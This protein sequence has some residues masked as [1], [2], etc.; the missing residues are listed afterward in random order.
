MGLSWQQGPPRHRGR[1]VPHGRA[2]ARAAAVRRA[3]PPADAGAFR[4]RVDRRQ[5]GRRPAARARPLPGRVLPARG[6][7]GRR[8]RRR[9][10]AR[11]A[12][13]PR[14][15][16]V[17]HGDAGDRSAARAAWQLHRPARHAD[18]LRDR[19]A[20]AWRAMDAFYEE[21]E[22]IVGHAADPYHR[23]DI[24]RT[25]RHLVV[26]AA[27]GSSPTHAPVVLYESGFAPRWYVPREDIDADRADARPTGRR[28]AR[29]RAWPATT[30]SA[31]RR[32]RPGPTARPGPRS[33]ASPTWSRSSRT[34]SRSSS[35]AGGSPS[36][37]GQTVIAARRRPRPG[38]RRDRLL[39]RWRRR[40]KENGHDC[41]P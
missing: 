6:R 28:S 3:A 1:A 24:R 12:P 9:P 37:P 35:T 5:R 36:N 18:V 31:D 17:V 39:E 27:T 14:R 30:T 33:G 41:R 32:A 23:I 34:R 11:P 15:H 40:H 29:T 8:A 25:S 2:A 4:R 20:F 16:R 13:R 21:D 7:T 38:P 22:R 19:V 10:T 26:R